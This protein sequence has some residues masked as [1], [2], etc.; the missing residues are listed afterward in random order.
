MSSSAAIR[1]SIPAATSTGI[2]C[3][4]HSSNP[5]RPPRWQER[6][7]DITEIGHQVEHQRHVGQERTIDGSRHGL[8]AG[9]DHCIHSAECVR[10]PSEILRPPRGHDV[11]VLRRQRGAVHEGRE[12]TDHDVVDSPRSGSRRSGPGRTSMIPSWQRSSRTLLDDQEGI[13][14]FDHR[15][16]AL[17]HRH[18]KLPTDLTDVDASAVLYPGRLFH[19]LSL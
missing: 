7:I 19:I 10:Q 5:P 2:A 18:A 15:P 17:G 11:D 6:Q 13:S 14:S 3:A 8:V 4:F 12:S 1:T 9:S 16:H